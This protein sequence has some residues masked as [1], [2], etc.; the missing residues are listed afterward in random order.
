MLNLLTCIFYL[1]H[2]NNLILTVLPNILRFYV[3]Y[4]SN[5]W[6]LHWVSELH[7]NESSLHMF[8]N[9]HEQLDLGNSYVRHRRAC[10]PYMN[11]EWARA[12]A[13]RQTAGV[14]ANRPDKHPP[15]L[16]KNAL[17]YELANPTTITL[18]IFYCNCRQWG[19]QFPLQFYVLV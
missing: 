10:R 17:I 5:N 13:T 4:Y 1:K 18:F 7:N 3:T 19:Y 6:Y 15:A 12:H 11:K 14:H 16:P 2:N 8:N 9:F